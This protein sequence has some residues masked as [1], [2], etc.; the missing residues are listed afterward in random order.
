HRERK[1]DGAGNVGGLEGFP[2]QDV[3]QREG[4]VPQPR[5]NLGKR[6]HVVRLA[7]TRTLSIES[8]S[9]SC[10]KTAQVHSNHT[11]SFSPSEIPGSTVT[12]MPTSLWDP[13]QS[14]QVSASRHLPSI[15]CP[16]LVTRVGVHHTRRVN[17]STLLRSRRSG[18]RYRCEACATPPAAKG[19]WSG[20]CSH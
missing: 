1:A 3:H 11:G 14:S 6:H 20:L 8:H 18:T 5:P 12:R 13:R 10:G 2:R 17:G 15:R 19:A 16:I 4:R 9:V 7:R